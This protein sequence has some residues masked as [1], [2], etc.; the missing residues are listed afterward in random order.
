MKSPLSP[1]LKLEGNS[2][3]R[4]CFNLEE[5]KSA[6]HSYDDN[7]ATLNAIIIRRKEE[8]DDATN[9]ECDKKSDS[10]RQP[11]SVENALGAKGGETDK[12]SE[13][14]LEEKDIEGGKAGV[15][16]LKHGLNGREGGKVKSF[17][18]YFRGGKRRGGDGVGGD[19]E[20]GESNTITSSIV[21]NPYAEN[22]VASRLPVASSPI[23]IA[24]ALIDNSMDHIIISKK[25]FREVKVDTTNGKKWCHIIWIKIVKRYNRNKSTFWVALARQFRLFNRSIG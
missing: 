18:E 12:E 13:M 15:S 23:A 20:E 11:T 19:G 2:K 14:N 1:N 17:F 25:K 21:N 24:T 22:I 7:D 10:S 9:N 5:G 6:E 8:Y 4:L 3:T 16:G